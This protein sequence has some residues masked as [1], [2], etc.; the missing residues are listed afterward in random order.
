[1]S[2]VDAVM[3]TTL[4]LDSRTSL[5]PV[6][7]LTGHPSIA[8]PNG[9][10]ANGSPAGVMF[11]GHLYRAEQ[12]RVLEMIK[13]GDA[14]KA[15][16]N[17]GFL[18]DAGLITEFRG[19]DS[20]GHARRDVHG[21]PQVFWWLPISLLQRVIALK[22]SRQRNWSYARATPR[23]YTSLRFQQW[24]LHQPPM[25]RTMPLLRKSKT[26]QARR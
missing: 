21:L 24:R 6:M 25:P 12:A 22:G 7:S 16:G 2:G 23:R 9:F 20:W 19:P 1:M 10:R 5:N 13:T 3:F 18:L 4:T 26:L 11:S 15:A 17:L 14:D 8:V